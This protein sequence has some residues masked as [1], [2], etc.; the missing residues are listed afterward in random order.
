MHQLGQVALILKR[1][2]VGVAQ[3]VQLR[4]SV[5]YSSEILKVQVAVDADGLGALQ[6]GADYAHMVDQ[7]ENDSLEFEAG[8]PRQRR[9]YLC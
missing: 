7:V 9:Q 5:S 2:L 6:Q 4:W 3:Q 1:V 8:Q